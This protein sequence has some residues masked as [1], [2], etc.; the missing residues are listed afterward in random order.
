MTPLGVLLSGRGTNFLALAE[1]IQRSEVPGRIAL[2]ASDRSDAPGLDLA[3]ARG[4]ETA[5]LPYREGRDR[6]EE[7][8]EDLLSRHGIRH[9]VLAGFMRILSAPFVGRHRGEIINLHP[10]LL[11]SFPGAQGIRDAWEH[12]VAVT[13]VTVHLVDEEVDHGPILAQE[14]VP[15][16][17]QDTLEA[18]EDRIHETEHRIYPRTIARWLREGNF[19]RKGRDLR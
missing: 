5:V 3:R 11:P 10:A 1:A 19:S 8:L 15:V 9:L 2:V 4:L 14:A 13:G 18:L 7:V 16:L 6:G 12:G 17:P